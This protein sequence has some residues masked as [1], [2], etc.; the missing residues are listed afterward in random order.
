MLKGVCIPG[1]K[2]PAS[3]HHWSGETNGFHTTTQ[4]DMADRRLFEPWDQFGAL[5]LLK[6]MVL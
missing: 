4:A 6:G 5:E 1:C 2:L 3:L